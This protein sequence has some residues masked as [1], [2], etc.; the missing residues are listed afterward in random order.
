MQSRKLASIILAVTFLVLATS[1]SQTP[2]AAAQD[3]SDEPFTLSLKNVDIHSLIETV[4]I[5]TGRNFIVDPR[6]KATVNV[7]SSEPV[8]AAKLYEIFLSVLQIHGYAAV[9]AGSITKIIPASVG[10][11]SAVPLRSENSDAADQ[12][13]SEVVR[14]QSVPALQVIEALRPLLPE[15]ASLS[16][17][18]TSNTIVVTDRA[19]NIEKIIEL[20]TLMDGQ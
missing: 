11:Q 8:N 18:S 13:V 2:R 9:E 5:H 6:V 16:A 10:V 14:L 17:E 15:S 4:S 19:A 1:L 3:I 12:L 7:V 20:I